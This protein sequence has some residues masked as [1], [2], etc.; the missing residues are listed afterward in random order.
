MKKS[1][2]E[3]PIQLSDEMCRRFDEN[4]G[5]KEAINSLA[6]ELGIRNTRLWKDL[7][8]MYGDLTDVYYESASKTLVRKE[9][10]DGN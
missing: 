2:K 8:D 4:Q 1:K 10:G 5:I 7:K 6:M 3:F 9:K